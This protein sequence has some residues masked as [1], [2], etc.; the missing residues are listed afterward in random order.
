MDAWRLAWRDTHHEQF[1]DML[2]YITDAQLAAGFVRQ[3]FD[4]AARI[5]TKKHLRPVKE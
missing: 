2:S 4:T 5:L 3:A 1:A